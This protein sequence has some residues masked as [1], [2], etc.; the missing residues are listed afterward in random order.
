L[1]NSILTG[2]VGMG[3]D[4]FLAAGEEWTKTCGPWFVYLNNVPA[5][6]T[7]PGKAAHALYADALAQAEAERRA[8]PYG[9]F[10]H[11][12]YVPA[13][14]RGTVKGKFVIRDWGKPNASAAGLWVGLVDQP[15]TIKGFYDFQKWLRPYQFWV[16]ADEK[17]EFTIPNV[18]PGT[19]YTLWAYGAGT[20]GTFLSQN[21]SGGAPPILHDLPAKP[22][23]VTV[24]A[25]KETDLGTVT[26]TPAR[27]GATV[28]ELGYPDRKASEF[29]HGED[30]W[31]PEKSPK[32]GY[33][34]PVWGAQMYFPADF[35][36]GMN[37]V[38]GKGRWATDWNYVLPSLPDRAGNY[39]PCAGTL[40]FRLAKAP[41]AEAQASI[42]LGCAGD[43]GG[44][45][46]VSVNGTDLATI[47]GVTA[48]PNPFT[49][50]VN[51]RNKGVG[52]FN[53]PYP[54]TSSIHFADHGP[55]S[56]ERITFPG[57]LLRAGENTITLTKNTRNLVDY[58]MV[59]YLRL[60][61]T[62]H[63]PPAPEKVIAY[64]GN[65]R[66]L[67]TWPVVPGVD[68]YKVLR[69]NLGQT[70]YEV[71]ASDKPGPV[72]GSGPGI[73]EYV[74]ATAANGTQYQYVVQSVN[75]HGASGNSAPSAGVTPSA[76]LPATP[77][78]VPTGLK[79]V[80]S[81]HHEV[82]LSWDPATGANFYRVYRT[83]L[84]KDGVG[85]TYPLWTIL[86]DDAVTGTNFTD[87]SPTDGKIYRYHVE[88]TS[89]GGT[90]GPSAQ[91]T[92]VP[93]PAAP[94]SAPESLKGGWIKTRQGNAVALEWS[95]V[96]GATGYVIYRSTK[97]DGVFRW[98]EDFLTTVGSTIYVDQDEKKPPKD[99]N[100][101]LSPA[102]DYDYRV[103]AVN[104]AGISPPA[105][106]RVKAR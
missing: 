87:R 69:S 100:K 51:G 45:V 9:W 78:P 7:D 3:S 34:T 102:R 44:H 26:W 60:E 54:D 72:C 76:K 67:V 4:G 57:D 1:N 49:T 10:K 21:L 14:G 71:I 80:R 65:N 17:G 59:D 42:Y 64:P 46:V 73:V 68:G 77:P 52:G 98:P 24:T 18:L 47:K 63:V 103:S 29:R 90:S 86:L 19:N 41:A 33:P 43:D 85:G 62:G 92:A 91:V 31:S 84:Y 28:F 94:A 88:A 89:A 56:D 11:E 74:D 27:V 5:S 2:E 66:N 8:W 13:S 75:S 81:G 79:V 97:A 104:A 36:D 70:G 53:P 61:L 50:E 105:T 96:P 16:R 99:P 39:Q 15:Y 101:A 20:A 38:V 58:L 40:T 22:F 95:A 6:I 93:L 37:F 23:A 82:A 12:K 35:P 83:T 30:F 32:L 106:V 55:F 25:G 48:R